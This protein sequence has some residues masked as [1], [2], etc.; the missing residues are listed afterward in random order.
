MFELKE[1]SEEFDLTDFYIKAKQKGYENNSSQK[2]LIDC[3]NNEKEKQVWILFH[4]GKPIGSVASHSLELLG[5]NSYRICA[6]TC[7][8]TDETGID[9][10]RTIRKTIQQH[11]NITAQYFIPKCIEWAGKDKDL[12]ISS[13]S[14]KS[15]SQRLVHEIYCPSL[16]K[17]GALTKHTEKEYRGMIQTFWKLNTDIFLEQLEKYGRWH[18]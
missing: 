1:W 7:I 12:F 18:S 11:Q 3:F 13:N 4:C 6:R 15:A 14:S 5:K 8:L 16:E 9:H 17:T 10:L 2:A